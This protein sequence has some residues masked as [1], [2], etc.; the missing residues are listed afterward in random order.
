MT[1]YCGLGIIIL[2]LVFLADFSRKNQKLLLF[3]IFMIL[4]IASAVR[5]NIG[6]D[7]YGHEQLYWAIKSGNFFVTEPLYLLLNVICIKLG[8]G[9]QVIVAIMSFITLYPIYLISKKEKISYLFLL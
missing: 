6:I 5:Y 4:F 9:F 1:F 8:F 7:Y 3:L 2:I